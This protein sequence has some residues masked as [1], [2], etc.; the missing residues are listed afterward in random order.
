MNVFATDCYLL[1]SLSLFVLYQSWR[2]NA[3]ALKRFFFVSLFLSVFFLFCYTYE[4]TIL[5]QNVIV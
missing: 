4:R 1:I 3:L 2:C 5:E